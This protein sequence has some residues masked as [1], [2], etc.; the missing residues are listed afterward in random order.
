MRPVRRLSQR[1][2]W[3]RLGLEQW[4]AVNGG[5]GK[6]EESDLW[7]REGMGRRRKGQGFQLLL[8]GAVMAERSQGESQLRE[9]IHLSN[10]YVVE[11]R[12]HFTCG[13][14]INVW[15]KKKKKA[16]WEEGATEIN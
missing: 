10:L 15:G 5:E 11:S 8:P 16:K 13:N 3:R 14:S 6:G 7:A 9:R 12:L 4:V 1:S 2:R